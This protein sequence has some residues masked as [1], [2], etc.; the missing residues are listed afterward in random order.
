[1]T[2]IEI[3]E[4]AGCCA[5]SSVVID[6]NALHFNADMDWCKQQGFEVKRHNLL[7]NPQSFISNP[8]VKAFLDVS[9]TQSLPVTLVNDVV[10]LTGRLPN[11]EEL[12]RWF[13]AEVTPISTAPTS[14]C[15]PTARA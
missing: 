15:T 3:F 13:G 9:G 10:A 8:R 7:K 1:M 4:P 2:T 6:Q 11:R 12:A 14:C 5:T